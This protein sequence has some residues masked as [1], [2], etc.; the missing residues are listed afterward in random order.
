MTLLTTAT[1][2]KDS[3]AHLQCETE[4]FKSTIL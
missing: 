3:E 1:Y 4:G 2:Q